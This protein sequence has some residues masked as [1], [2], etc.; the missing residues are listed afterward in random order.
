MCFVVGQAHTDIHTHWLVTE[1]GLFL[2]IMVSAGTEFDWKL[3]IESL[4]HI[5]VWSPQN[6][7]HKYDIKIMSQS[8]EEH[9]KCREC[10]LPF[11][12]AVTSLMNCR[13]FIT[14]VFCIFRFLGYDALYGWSMFTGTL[15]ELCF[16]FLKSVLKGISV[17]KQ[18]H[19]S[20]MWDWPA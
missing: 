9:I 7:R 15:R 2:S 20:S 8:S 10:L 18:I 17:T 4:M 5:N 3:Y 12:S 13:V 1:Y 16:H 11:R 19:F 14:G 6:T